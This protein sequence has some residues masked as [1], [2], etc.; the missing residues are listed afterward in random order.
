MIWNILLAIVTVI[1]VACVIKA[2]LYF[3]DP[4]SEDND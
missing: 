4:F 1:A 3:I 2:A